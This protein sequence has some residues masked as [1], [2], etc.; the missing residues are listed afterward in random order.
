MGMEV[1]ARP[2][3]RSGWKFSM[4]VAAGGGAEPD[5]AVEEPRCEASACGGIASWAMR[6]ASAV[7]NANERCDT[8]PDL[9]R[10]R[11]MAGPSFF[12]GLVTGCL[13]ADPG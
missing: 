1:V 9:F 7:R 2:V 12:V 10:Q 11:G 8:V 3:K 13:V 6:S 5:E 4:R